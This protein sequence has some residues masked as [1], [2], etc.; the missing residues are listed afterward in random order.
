M[1]LYRNRG[2]NHNLKEV[3]VVDYTFIGTEIRDML[4]SIIVIKVELPDARVKQY[5]RIM[6]HELLLDTLRMENGK[7]ELFR[8]MFENQEYLPTKVTVKWDE[9]HK[10][11]ISI[12][13]IDPHQT[14]Y[15][16]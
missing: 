1:E 16:T 14:G 15:I 9:I 2:F 3:F 5:W 4:Y 11:P 13:Y 6:R 7:V 8:E 12:G 10:K